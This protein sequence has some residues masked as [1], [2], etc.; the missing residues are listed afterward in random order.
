MK[1]IK[2]IPEDVPESV[3]TEGKDAW[4]DVDCVQRMLTYLV[5]LSP[6]QGRVMYCFNEFSDFSW[7]LVMQD[8]QSV[9]KGG[10]LG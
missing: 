4:G 1:M 2:T 10:Y 9:L 5:N 3:V 8:L 7:F 6:I